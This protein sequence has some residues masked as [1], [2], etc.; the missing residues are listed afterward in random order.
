MFTFSHRNVSGQ[1]FG[2]PTPLSGLCSTCILIR[3]ERGVLPKACPKK[4][5]VI[6]N[7]TV[8][9]FVESRLL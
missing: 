5:N 4:C 8:L 1:A 6:S 2:R 9:R 3:T 7:E